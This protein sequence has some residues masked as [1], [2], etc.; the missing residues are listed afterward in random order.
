[1][2]EHICKEIDYCMCYSLA[3]EPDEQCPVHGNPWPHRCAIC[4]K[5]MRKK[6]DNESLV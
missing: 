4:G 3:L 5:F 6:S 1:M 2:S